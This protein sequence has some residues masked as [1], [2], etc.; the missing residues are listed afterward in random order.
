VAGTWCSKDLVLELNR[1]RRVVLTSTRNFRGV[2]G[3]DDDDDARG[4]RDRVGIIRVSSRG[5]S[6]NV[7]SCFLSHSHT[8]A[9][10]DS[11]EMA[12]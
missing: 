5:S 7:E 3:D 1:C 9:L 6:N 10:E 2:G 11:L 4:S 8:T 12:W